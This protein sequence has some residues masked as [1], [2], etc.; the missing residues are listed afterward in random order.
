MFFAIHF[1]YR[2]E[3]DHIGTEILRGCIEVSVLVEHH[4][5]IM[6]LSIRCTVNVALCSCSY[7]CSHQ[8]S[9]P[10]SEPL[11]Y[12]T[13]L[14]VQGSRLFYPALYPL[15]AMGEACLKP[16]KLSKGGEKWLL[17]KEGKIGFF[18]LSRA[19]MLMWIQI[20]YMSY[21]LYICIK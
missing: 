12:V 16:P 5:D 2:V 7:Y 18:I 4:E 9:D 20:L 19:E 6:D 13:S 17:L 21:V 10:P 3:I 8:R 11:P 15:S 1:I 14:Q